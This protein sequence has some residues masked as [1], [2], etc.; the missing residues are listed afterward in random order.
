MAKLLAIVLA[1]ASAPG[2]AQQGNGATNNSRAGSGNGSQNGNGTANGSAPVYEDRLIED[3]KLEPDLWDGLT[4][5]NNAEG[6]PRELRLD[7]LWSQQRRNDLSTSQWGVGVGGFLGTPQYGSFSF[8]GLFTNGNDTSLATLWQR[9]MPFDDG[10]RASNALGMLNT[11][12]IDLVRFQPRIFLPT[13]PMVGALT[14]WRSPQGMMLTAGY[15]EPG[16]YVGAYVPEFRRL[17]GAITNLGAQ[18]TD[19]GLVSAG[20]QYA[21]ASDVT[22]AF[23][24]SPDVQAFS[25]RSF[26]FAT[27]RQDATSR[28]QFNV[29]QTE[30][31]LTPSHHGAWFDGVVQS[32]RYAQSLG[33][34]WLE[35]GLAWANQP[36]ANDA[37]G[38]YYRVFY[39]GPRWL[40]DA[41]AEYTAPVN[42]DATQ[43]ST[44]LNGSARYQFFRDLGAG[45]GA[46]V[47]LTDSTAWQGFTYVE[48]TWRVLTERTQLNYAESGERQETLLNFNQTWNTPAG[49]RLNTTIG[50]GRFHDDRIG[51]SRQLLLSV[52]G[53]GD[54]ARNLALDL[55]LQYLR[56]Y[57]DARPTSTTGSI[58]LT[59]A[60]LPRLQLIATAYRSLASTRE[61][62]TISS[63]LDQLVPTRRFDDTGAFLI[64]R[65]ATRAGSLGAPLGGP[66]GTGAGRIAGVVFLDAND[67]GRFEAGE[68]GAA[69]V[70]VLLDG[71]Y[72]TRTDAQ[73]RFEFPAVASGPHFITVMS[74]NLPLPW[75]LAGDAR[76]EFEVPVRGTV[77]VDV[78]A[79][80]MR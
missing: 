5:L 2:F 17:G 40:W 38:G 8:D 46:N 71:R 25:T 74:D 51:D 52:Y 30:S 37:R 73:G 19:G 3:G 9:D 27:S 72:S 15:G 16:V 12:A 67:S 63:P 18:W 34:Y 76:A 48:N 22:S 31:T 69:N 68:Q 66:P 24:D 56:T 11:P 10:W 4:P 65:F 6:L 32:G 39:S 33:L 78:G 64:L 13:T 21:G 62:L 61:P 50:V 36:V 26:M 1:L 43:P 28:Y 60:I 42:N 44:Y 7:G 53:G 41:G 23:Q 55:N 20:F 59:W 58:V 29:L 70:T 14:E 77:N 54:I 49:T 47:L 79:Q 75:T 45:A 35:Q 80:R 57:D